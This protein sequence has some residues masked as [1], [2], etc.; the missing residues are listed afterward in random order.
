[1]VLTCFG[2]LKQVFC[3]F[4]EGDLCFV[5]VSPTKPFQ[6][7]NKQIAPTWLTGP[8][9]TPAEPSHFQIPILGPSNKC[10][11]EALKYIQISP[12]STCWKVLLYLKGINQCQQKRKQPTQPHTVG[13]QINSHSIASRSGSSSCWPVR[14][15]DLLTLTVASFQKSGGGSFWTFNHPNQEEA[16]MAA[17]TYPNNLCLKHPN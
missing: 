11:W 3:I 7:S 16:A 1:M 8:S 14:L 12:D 6:P 5:M 17:Q 4:L 15:V 13:L 9:S 2:Y 10:F